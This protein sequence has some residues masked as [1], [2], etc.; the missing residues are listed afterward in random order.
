MGFVVA[1]DSSTTACKAIACDE[2]GAILAEGRAPL[3]LENP[4]PDGW[5]Q[6]AERWW[7]ALGEAVRALSQSLPQGIGPARAL[8]V[9]H[10]RETV[11]VVDRD[12]RP[13]RP[14]LVWMDKRCAGT[15]ERLG[16]DRAAI[17]RLGGKPICTT[18]SAYKLR[19]L[20][21]EEPALREAD[22]A[23]EVH[24]FLVSRLVGRRVTSLAS[25][26]PTGLVAMEEG[27]WSQ[28]LIESVLGTTR[29]RWPDLVAPGIIVGEVTAE[30][31]VATG[32]PAGLPV[33][34]GAGDG[35]CAGLGAGITEPGRAY[36]NL[37]TAIVSGVL[38]PAYRTDLAYRTLYGPVAPSYFL[39]TD[40]QG[41]TFTLSWL[42]ERL[43]GGG[44]A[45]RSDLERRAAALSA[46]AEGLLLVPYWNGV[47]NP[48]WDDRAS[49]LIAGFRGDHE[50]AHLYRALLEGIA[51]EERWHL[52]GVEAATEPVREVVVMGG[53]SKS[54]LW[55]QILADVLERDVVRAGTS[56]ATALGAAVLAA[57][58]SGMHA[59]PA[60]ACT[61]MTHLGARFSPRPAFARFYRRLF[62]EVY[63]GLYAGVQD[64]M[65][66]LALLRAEA[67][68]EA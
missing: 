55:C 18:P 67:P 35:Q 52:E 3:A 26:D 34:A 68:P 2:R 20:L 58:A 43:F 59:S 65:R 36:L 19:W 11:V 1:I 16:L 50:P 33:V 12:T 61:A 48:T 60:E 13:L 24:G 62:E 27:C 9:T 37:G 29:W 51:L 15:V 32:L 6:D 41:G 14:A 56:E 57:V 40:L 38:S 5:E 7:S 22:A 31:A 30:A 8:C 66:R 47:M 46:G 54:D 17:H 10:Q 64:R 45:L 49:G 63:R 44:E 4:A 53:G 28:M 23:L 39:E 25:A 21:E 42:V